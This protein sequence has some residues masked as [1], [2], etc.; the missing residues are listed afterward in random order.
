MDLRLA[1]LGCGNVGRAFIALVATKDAELRDRYGLHLR[2]SGGLTRSAGGWQAASGFDAATL[3]AAGWPEGDRPAGSEP[4]TGDGQAFAATCPADVVVE[5]TT[6]QPL[7]GQP[8]IGHVRAALAAGR[9]VVTANKGPI[10]HAYADLQALASERRVVLRFES[11]VLDGTPLFNLAEF[12]LPATQIRGFRGPLNSTSNYVLSHMA[13][14]AALED[15]LAE[16][17]RAGIAEANPAYDLDGW[18]A[19]VKA[20]VLATALLHAD[21][22]PGDVARE[23]LGAAAMRAAHAALPAGHTLKQLVE[24]R[25]TGSGAVQAVVR[26]AALPPSDLLAHLSGMETG[27]MLQTD[28]MGDLTLIESAGG[29]GQTAFGVLADLVA[30]ARTLGGSQFGARR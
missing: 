13:A 24:A 18:D 5:L 29:P 28:T 16:A 23:G 12:T 22:R 25:R 10:A 15:A 11:T 21:L 17:Q 4:F 8:A 14:G 1:L 20:T 26:L 3:A 30:V 27:L 7:T 9:H 6:L 19:A 2:F